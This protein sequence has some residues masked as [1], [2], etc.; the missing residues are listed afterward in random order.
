MIKFFIEHLHVLM[1]WPEDMDVIL[2]NF[3]LFLFCELKSNK[4]PCIIIAHIFKDKHKVI[5]NIHFLKS[6]DYCHAI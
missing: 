4:F 1:S 6:L 2:I 5:G 3:S